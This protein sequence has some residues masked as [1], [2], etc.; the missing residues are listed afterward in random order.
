MSQ[1]QIVSVQFHDQS[2]IAIEHE[3]AHFVAMR[4][5]VETSGLTGRLNCNASSAIPF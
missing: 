4:P 1:Y 2:I 5:I 3:G